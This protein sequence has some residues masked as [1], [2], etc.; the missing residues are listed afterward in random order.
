MTSENQV[1]LFC[2]PWWLCGAGV[3]TTHT[4]EAVRG[5]ADKAGYST[6]VIALR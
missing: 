3:A 5:F 4:Q 1:I 2:F 6:T